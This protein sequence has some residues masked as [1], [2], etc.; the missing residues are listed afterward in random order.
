MAT[1]EPMILIKKADGTTE[2]VPLSSV[3]KRTSDDRQKATDS[4]V[5]SL[6]DNTKEG[7]ETDLG[8]QTSDAGMRSLEDDTK[9]IPKKESDVDRRQR[10]TD[11]STQSLVDNTKEGGETDL[12]LQ[13]SDSGIAELGSNPEVSAT[14]MK[15]EVVVETQETPNLPVVATPHELAMTTPVDD[16]FVDLAKA[17][18]WDTHDHIS[19]LEESLDEGENS[20]TEKPPLPEDRYEDVSR[21]VEVLSFDIPQNLHLRLHSLI[22]SRVKDVRSDHQLSSY[23]MRAIESGGL[24]LTEE[25][26]EILVETIH[27]VLAVRKEVA[28]PGTKMTVIDTPSHSNGSHNL[29]EYSPERGTSISAQKNPTVSLQ[30]IH[31][32][33][34][35]DEVMGPIDEIASMTLHHFRSL[36]KDPHIAIDIMQKKIDTLR[37]ESYFEYIK[38]QDAWQKSPLYALYLAHLSRALDTNKHLKDVLDGDMGEDD[39]A[40]IASFTERLRF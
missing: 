1:Q 38:A 25:Q 35:R 18:E 26:A 10:T 34:I 29:R 40:V 5:Q 14:E 8:L 27:T 4:S 9:E 23:A 11:M 39:I 32:P 28:I 15:E 13:T 20:H 16:F 2:R 17:K 6:V 19:L 24:G 31:P 33:E 12:G 21:V 37:A 3:R 36:S 30:D 22:Q 7:S